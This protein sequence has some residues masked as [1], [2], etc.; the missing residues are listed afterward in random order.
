MEIAQ[1]DEL[2]LVQGMIDAW[3]EEADGLVLIDYKTDQV[4]GGRGNRPLIL[5]YR[6]QMDYYKRSLEQ[7][8][9][10][11]VKEILFIPLP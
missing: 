8:T 7:I 6:T 9:G 4:G 3:I 10:K 2:V 1:S 11:K 5:R